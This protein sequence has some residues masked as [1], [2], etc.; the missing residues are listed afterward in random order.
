[1]TNN[2]T[3]ET[4]TDIENYQQRSKLNDL[5]ETQSNQE[6]KIGLYLLYDTIAEL[7]GPTFEAVNDAVAVRN[8]NSMKGM[9]HPE[10]FI[11]KRV[12][13]RTGTVILSSYEQ[14]EF[15]KTGDITP[16]E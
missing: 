14:I 5:E 9:Q 6:T 7:H 16:N 4:Q 10:D 1:M 13:Y 2:K 12:A 11:L 8:I 15:L 3:R